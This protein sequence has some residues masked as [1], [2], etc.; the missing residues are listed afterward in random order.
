MTDTMPSLLTYDEDER[1]VAGSRR[2][3]VPMMPSE[4]IRIE[5]AMYFANVGDRTIREWAKR[6]GIGRQADRHAPLQISLPALL[7]K[8]DGDTRT[9]DR[10]R[11]GDRGHP[12]VVHYLDRAVAMLDELRRPKHK[13]R[14]SSS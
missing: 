8:V 13:R 4:I 9:I 12:A 1:G 5:T 2:R 7:M 14:A 3:P 11:S 10:L 6:Y